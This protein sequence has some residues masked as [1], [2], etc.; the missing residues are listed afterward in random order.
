M[1]GHEWGG[2]GGLTVKKNPSQI[3]LNNL[4]LVFKCKYMATL[5]L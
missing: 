2:G 1:G 5:K 4:V 3:S